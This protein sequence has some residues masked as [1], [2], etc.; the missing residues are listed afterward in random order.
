MHDI[1]Y[2]S[3]LQHP[4]F[5]WKKERTNIYTLY[6]NGNKLCIKGDIFCLETNS[7]GHLSTIKEINFTNHEN[8]YC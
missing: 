3:T 8:A 6:D 1:L 5:F 4:L 2:I 7:N